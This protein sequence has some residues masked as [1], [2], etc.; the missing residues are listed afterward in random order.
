V[1]TTP[2]LKTKNIEIEVS[3]VSLDPKE[4]G[5]FG[6]IVPQLD[7]KPVETKYDYRTSYEQD[8]KDVSART[9]EFQWGELDHETGNFREM[10]KQRTE[11]LEGE[12]LPWTI[13]SKNLIPKEGKSLWL[14][15]PASSGPKAIREK[16]ARDMYREGER[17]IRDQ[18]AL[19]ASFSWGH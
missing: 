4:I 7:G 2:V 10:S 1:I 3:T 12:E 8:G 5:G 16:R 6:K 9:P 13:L 11:V 19:A 15:R 17:F 14:L 18:L